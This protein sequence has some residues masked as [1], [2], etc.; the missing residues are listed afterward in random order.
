[1]I[2]VMLDPAALRIALIGRSDLA[3]RRLAW[4]RNLGGDPTVYSDAP[5]PAL[6]KAAWPALHAHL[7]DDAAWKRIDVAWIADIDPERAGALAAAARSHRVLINVEDVLPLCDFHTPAV[8]QRGKLVLAAGTGGASPAAAGA[9]RRK[10]EQAFPAR[11][12]DAIDA[13]AADRARAR[14]EGAT[15]A[16]VK[17]RAREILAAYGLY[18]EPVHG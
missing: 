2:P 15:P 8:V 3:V 13:L 7:P 5:S 9:A 12:A 16:Q 17:A 6:A 10:L 14:A 11:W 18:E 4:L 1:M